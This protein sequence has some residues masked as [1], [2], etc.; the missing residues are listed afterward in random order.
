MRGFVGGDQRARQAVGQRAAAADLDAEADRQVD[1]QPV[2]PRRVAEQGVERLDMVA[3]GQL[4]ILEPG[5]DAAVALVERALGSADAK[6]RHDLLDQLALAVGRK[7]G[8]RFPHS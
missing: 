1:R 4:R 6:A 8:E 3:E 2:D 5:E 7:G